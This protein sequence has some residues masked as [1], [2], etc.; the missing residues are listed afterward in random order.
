MVKLDST[1]SLLDADIIVFCPGMAIFTTSGG[2][3]AFPVPPIEQ[4]ME[5]DVQTDREN[6]A[7]VRPS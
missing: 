3:V 5:T 6:T 2:V 7:E 4:I 1:Q